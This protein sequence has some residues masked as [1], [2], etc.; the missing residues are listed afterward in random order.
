MSKVSCR[1]SSSFSAPRPICMST[2]YS[3]T[4]RLWPTLG[5]IE[6]QDANGQRIVALS[7]EFLQ[8]GGVHSWAYVKD[9]TACCV[10]EE[11]R[12]ANLD[13]TVVDESSAPVAGIYRFLRSGEMQDGCTR[14]GR[15]SLTTHYL[16]ADGSITPCTPARGPRMQYARRGPSV[17]SDASTMSASSKT[18]S[19]V[20]QVRR[21]YLRLSLR[22]KH[23]LNMSAALVYLS[24]GAA[25]SGWRL[26]TDRSRS[27]DSRMSHTSAKSS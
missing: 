14:N 11:G 2:T 20:N 27:W 17:D 23:L 26:S 22:L 18:G 16:P 5:A 7:I 8:R 9:V 3:L 12:V 24:Q 19:N 10:V 1:V 15:Q 13:G 6:I 25:G 21:E 4:T